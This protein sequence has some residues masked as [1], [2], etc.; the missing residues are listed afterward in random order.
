[1]KPWLIWGA[2]V[3]HLTWAILILIDRTAL[4]ATATDGLVDLV[5][6][7]YVLVGIL[8]VTSLLAI[9]GTTKS[10]YI[11][12]FIPQQIVLAASAVNAFAAIVNAQFA[13][14]V[15]RSRSFIGADQVIVI[16]IAIFYG[17]S[18]LDYHI[19]KWRQIK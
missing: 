19:H 14:G 11:A 9:Y 15:V 13:D 4:F 8:L 17:C 12:W 10:H 3:L 1:M 6:N 18:V 2:C 16:V 5:T 7:R